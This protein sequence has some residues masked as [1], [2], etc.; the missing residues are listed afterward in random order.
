[1]QFL[2]HR[3]SLILDLSKGFQKQKKTNKNPL[4][5]RKPI[6]LFQGLIKAPLV[7]IFPTNLVI[8]LSFL[9][10]SSPSLSLPLSFFQAR[11]AGGFYLDPWPN[12]ADSCLAQTGLQQWKIC[13]EKNWADF[14]ASG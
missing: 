7:R 11:N 12:V 14:L 10:S 4:N 8:L 1:M 6:L 13:P 3:V 9:F 2:V 5:S